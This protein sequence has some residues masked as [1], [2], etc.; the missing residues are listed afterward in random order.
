MKKKFILV[1]ILV[2]GFL[3]FSGCSLFGNTNEGTNTNTGD[4]KNSAVQQNV[5]A[6]A[7]SVADVPEA[8]VGTWKSECLT[9]EPDDPWSEMHQFEIDEEGWATYTRWNWYEPN[10][11]GSM[12]TMVTE[13]LISF[14]TTGQIDLV[15]MNE[16]VTVYD[17]YQITGNA[18]LFGHGFRNHFP[19]SP[20]YGETADARISTLNEYIR[21][22]KVI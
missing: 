7:D 15:N 11:G 16:G 21:Y 9:P 6:P 4:N 14:P 5:N 22:Q 1:A 12:E 18:L 2:A 10:C 19:Y 20:T 17:I 13:Y 8:I 3:F